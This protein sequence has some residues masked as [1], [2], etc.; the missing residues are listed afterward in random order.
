MI[1]TLRVRASWFENRR[2]PWGPRTMTSS[3]ET[4][5][6]LPFR[7]SVTVTGVVVVVVVILAETFIPGFRSATPMSL[8]WY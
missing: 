6:T 2:I 8:P 5:R 3:P 4:A 7:I 1:L